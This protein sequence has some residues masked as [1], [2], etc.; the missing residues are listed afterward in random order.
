MYDRWESFLLQWAEKNGLSEKYIK[1]GL[2]R[3]KELPPKMLQLCR[4]LDISTSSS[5]QESVFSVDISSGISPCKAGGYSIEASI[6]GFSMEKTKGVMNII[7]EMVYSEELGLLMVKNKFANVKIFSSGSLV[8]NSEDKDTAESVF[9]EVSRQLL[10][11]HRCTC[12]RI[13]VKTCP[14]NAISID[15]GHV[16]VSEK[17]IRCGKCTDSCV[18]LRYENKLQ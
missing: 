6:H 12:C 1:H 2:W 13:C 15:D 17:C 3:W 14:V 7:G 18:V 8:V 11:A 16:C 5:S 4:D 10:K 9:R